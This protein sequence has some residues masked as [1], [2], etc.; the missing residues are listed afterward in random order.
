MDIN[1]NIKKNLQIRAFYLFFV[2]ASIQLGIGILG[3]SRLIYLEVQ[4]DAWISI[5]IAFFYVSLIIMVML[6]ILKQYENAD[7]YGIQV[8]IF[9]KWI[10]KLFGTFFI[11]HFALSFFSIL[12][13][14]IEVIKVFIFPTVNDY[15]LSFMLLC[16]VI[17]SVL[18][19]IRVIIGVCVIFFFLSHWLLILL[20]QPALQMELTHLQPVFVTPITDL[21][22]GARVTS[23]TFMGFEILFLIYPFILNKNKAKLPIF[24]GLGWTTFLLLLTTI[25]VIGYFSFDQIE[26]REWVLLGLFK[27]QS[28]AFI[29]RF[30]YIVVAEWMMVVI[31][32]LILLMWGITYGTKR[33]YQVPQR[34]TLYTIAILCFIGSL[35]TNE[36]FQIQKVINWSSEYGFWL[37]YVYP[38]LLLPIVLIKK[39]WQKRKDG[40]HHV[41]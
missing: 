20:I 17:Y 18:G 23:Y 3:V 28:F 14:Y 34:A 41:H 37:V 2:I 5:V 40:D 4:Q 21:L 8:D 24:L 15:I 25:L 29:E 1:I 35:F 19:G 7:I 38:L 36:H 22:K 27:I 9:G 39:K 26:R 13:T 32:S 33:L 6:L 16:L 12:I 31:P 30:D 10:G 11:F